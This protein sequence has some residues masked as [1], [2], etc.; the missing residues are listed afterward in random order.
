MSISS[1]NIK[2]F[3]ELGANV[4]N[5]IIS[6]TLEAVVSTSTLASYARSKGSAC[7]LVGSTYAANY[8]LKQFRIKNTKTAIDHLMLE[9]DLLSDEMFD[10]EINVSPVQAERGSYKYGWLQDN[11]YDPDLT[12]Q[13]NVLILSNKNTVAFIDKFKNT[14]T[15]LSSRCQ[16]GDDTYPLYVLT[17]YSNIDLEDSERNV[18]VVGD[19][20]AYPLL[21]QFPYET[22]YNIIGKALNDYLIYDNLG[23]EYVNN[24]PL[25]CTYHNLNHYIDYENHEVSHYH[26]MPWCSRHSVPFSEWDSSCPE[27]EIPQIIRP[28][29]TSLGMM[30]NGLAENVLV[31]P[32]DIYQAAKGNQFFFRNKSSYLDPATKE[33]KPIYIQR[34]DP[35]GIPL[36]ETYFF[37][38]IP[39]E[40]LNQ[41]TDFKIEKRQKEIKYTPQT[42]TVASNVEPITTSTTTSTTTS[43]V[44]TKQGGDT[45][46]AQLRTIKPQ[47]TVRI[48]NISNATYKSGTYTDENNELY[49]DFY[50]SPYTFS[51]ENNVASSELSSQGSANYRISNISDWNHETA[52][53][54]GVNGNGIGQWIKFQDISKQIDFITIL[55]GYVKNDKAWSENSRVKSLKVYCNDEPLCILE[56]QDSRSMQ[57]FSVGDLFEGK[58]IK[59]LRFEILEVYSGTKYQDTAISEI[60]FKYAP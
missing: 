50:C 23:N 22:Y 8:K 17:Q 18:R 56:L 60:Y 26:D 5:G 36:I 1:G 31:F 29:G 11:G 30:K 38:Y 34:K 57:S 33:W 6:V 39:L 46:G 15:S 55:N 59:T 35:I 32:E 41:I 51:A 21:V 37:A 48:L 40:T 12:F 52:W 49:W 9:L 20:F 58:N 43:D 19:V 54:E 10:Y 24:Y 16:E 47:R 53:V 3:K 2:S 45:E 27:S 13:I 25:T 14:I 28:R 42:N 44:V 4:Y 7:E